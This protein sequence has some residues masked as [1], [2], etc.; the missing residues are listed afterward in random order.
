MMRIKESER[1]FFLI[2]RLNIVRYDSY[3]ANEIAM[4]VEE[5]K[6]KVF[7]VIVKSF[8]RVLVSVSETSIV[9]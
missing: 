8:I 9:S 3:L 4:E 7:G 5:W 6:Q 1:I 2:F